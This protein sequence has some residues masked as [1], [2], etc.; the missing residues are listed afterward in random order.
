M[1]ERWS[2]EATVWWLKLSGSL[3]LP[4]KPGED[5]RKADAT[6]VPT[7]WGPWGRFESLPPVK[8]GSEWGG[9]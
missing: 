5:L 1:Q 3:C 8:C 6:L 9:L 4:D 7:S 2:A